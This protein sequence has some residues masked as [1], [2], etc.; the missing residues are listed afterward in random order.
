MFI[1][2]VQLCFA[3]CSFRSVASND[4]SDTVDVKE[5]CLFCKL[6]FEER[7]HLCF[8]MYCLIELLIAQ[9]RDQS[10]SDTPHDTSL[11]A[12]F[13]DQLESDTTPDTLL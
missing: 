5:P 4:I 2:S 7:G 13:R 8:E 9:F 3:L 10:E 6:S 12:Q 1:Q 11:I